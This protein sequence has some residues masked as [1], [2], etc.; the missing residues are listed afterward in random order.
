MNEHITHRA[1]LAKG[2]VCP[3]PPTDL[4]VTCFS[5]R[6]DQQS[7]D[8]LNVVN[9][10]IE[11]T[12][13]KTRP[14]ITSVYD[15]SMLITS[16]CSGLFDRHCFCLPEYQFLDMF[17]SSIG[18]AMNF[19]TQ[20]F[21]QFNRAVS[22]ISPQL[23]RFVRQ[24]AKGE[25]VS[26]GHGGEEAEPVSADALLDI[27][28]ETSLLVEIKDIRDELNIISVILAFQCQMAEQ[29]EHLVVEELQAENGRR[30]ADGVV[31]EVRKRGRE[32]ARLLDIY[33]RDIDRM[34]RQADIIYTNL[35]HL[36]DL[37][38]KHSNAL[39]ARF[40]RDQA[41]MAGRQGQT[42]MVFTLV[43]VV[44]L[45]MSF[46]ASFFGVEFAE[47][48][49]D[50]LLTIGYVSKYMFGIGLGIS[51]PLILMAMF[52]DEFMGVAK[53]SY[54]ALWRRMRTSSRAGSVSESDGAPLEVFPT[55][56]REVGLEPK[57]AF[58]TSHVVTSRAR[59]GSYA[60]DFENHASSRLSPVY[61][62]FPGS[63]VSASSR[64]NDGRLRFSGDLEM[65]SRPGS[66]AVY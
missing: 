37:K 61:G 43:T 7:Q 11:E 54:A 32:L 34:N 56:A 29:L 65:G 26:S 59:S 49:G 38:Q 40:A 66:R 55:V 58:S 60:R 46:I 50:G 5:Q 28:C 20:L 19:E 47:W 39:E 13:A 14:P 52:V 45:P 64:G 57:H 33:G 15:L 2:P 48:G 25:S 23:R 8:H 35:T 3:N 31:L 53:G 62:R 1:H 41:V 22:R 9:G 18:A 63:R 30:A 16:R 12:N 4:V 17:D 21:D 51:I 42:I 24:N 27:G 10:I 6:W 36:L 44:F